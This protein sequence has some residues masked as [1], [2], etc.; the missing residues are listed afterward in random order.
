M[1]NSSMI[2]RQERFRVMRRW[3]YVCV[4]REN[5]GEAEAVLQAA[6]DSGGNNPEWLYTLYEIQRSRGNFKGASRTLKRIRKN[7]GV[8]V[9][10]DDYGELSVRI[11]LE[12]G[13]TCHCRQ[14]GG[15]S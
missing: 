1:K 10:N 12:E 3:R 11:F 4:S 6:I 15:K 5:P 8:T 14:D 7:A 2:E 13:A 9:F